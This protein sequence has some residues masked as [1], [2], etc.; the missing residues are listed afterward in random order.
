VSA[1]DP[2]LTLALRFPDYHQHELWPASETEFYYVGFLGS[3]FAIAYDLRF[4]LDG[5]GRVVRLEVETGTG[6][7]RAEWLGP[8]SFVAEEAT[9]TATAGTQQPGGQGLGPKDRVWAVSCPDRRDGVYR[10]K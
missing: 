5:E 8:T 4:V 7:I 3:E 9:P 6:S 2:A 1:L 10:V